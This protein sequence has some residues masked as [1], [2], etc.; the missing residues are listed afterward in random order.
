MAYTFYPNKY[1][2]MEVEGDEHKMKFGW[3]WRKIFPEFDFV[4]VMVMATQLVIFEGRLL[5]STI[6]FCSNKFIKL[7]LGEII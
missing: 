1:C 7:W 6:L 3:N 2:S 4:F 5:I